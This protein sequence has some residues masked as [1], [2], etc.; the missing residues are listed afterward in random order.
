[1][2]ASK[3]M[4]VSLPEKV[5]MELDALAQT[6]N[7]SVPLMVAALLASWHKTHC[8]ECGIELSSRRCSCKAPETM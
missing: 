7:R 1:M 6:E 2:S 5:R 8:P 4:R 3:F